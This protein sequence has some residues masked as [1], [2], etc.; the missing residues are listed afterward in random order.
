[1][2]GIAPRVTAKGWRIIRKK[3]KV[4]KI[5][6]KLEQCL[7]STSSLVLDPK[8]VKSH[9]K[10]DIE[11]IKSSL[12]S[13]GFRQPLVVQKKGLVVRAGNGRL[14]AAKELGLDKVPAIIIDEK[15]TDAIAYSVTDNR[16]ADM[17]EWDWPNLTDCLSEIEFDWV[18]SGLYEDDEIRVLTNT[19]E[20]W[21]PPAIEED[22]EYE[23]NSLRNSS[24]RIASSNA[25]SPVRTKNKNLKKIEGLVSKDIVVVVKG[26]T[27][28]KL[29]RLSYSKRISADE[30]VR[31]LLE[32]QEE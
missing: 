16:T 29:R 24:Q 9:K 4:V 21:T 17:A 12:V 13:F 18:G 15:D 26:E 5:P 30:Y 7:V 31:I 3:H 14:M 1:M 11:A 22:V 8:N 32:D 19:V 6:E 28:E 25:D 2:R 10:K 23:A 27:A 20:E